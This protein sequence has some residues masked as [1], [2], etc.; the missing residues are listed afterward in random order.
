[1]GETET[2]A[3]VRAACERGRALRSGVPRAAHGAWEVEEGRT[4]PLE[5]LDEQAQQRLAYLV[6]E[7]YLRMSASPF[8]FFRGGALAMAADLA[9]TPATGIRVQVCGDAHLANFGGFASPER[10]LVFDINDF[11]ETAPGPWEWDVKR[12]A[13]SIEIC[14]RNRGFRPSWRRS[15][16]RSAVGSYREAMNAFSRMGALEVWYAQLDVVDV[17]TRALADVSRKEARR[18]RDKLEKAYGKTSTRAFEKHVRWEDGEL[19][20]MFDPPYLVP[21]DRFAPVADADRVAA[22]L[23]ELLA[24]YRESLSPELHCLFDRY[25]YLDAAQKVVGVGSVGTR[26]WIVAFADAQTGDPLV[27][28]VKEAQESVVERIAGP[29]GLPSHGERVVRGQRLMQAS[30]DMLLGYT[31]AEDEGGHVRDY[32]VRQLWDWKTSTDLDTAAPAEIEALGRLCGWTLARAHARSGDRFAIAG[33]LGT[34]SSFDRALAE[35]AASY[36]DQNEADFRMFIDALSEGSLATGGR[37][38]V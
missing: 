32:Y 24:G 19:R 30:S 29:C 6:P 12:L 27:L 8:A 20:I 25:T 38:R 3:G 36:A 13:A 9:R 5:L 34:G 2:D 11:D 33:Y 21:L 37:F 26:A 31:G 28:Q 14:G 18:V 17:L 16:V 35:F 10:H 1:M 4:G 23:V 7:R 15:A 22:S